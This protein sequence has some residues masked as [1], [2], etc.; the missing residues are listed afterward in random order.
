MK[1]LF[2]ASG[3]IPLLG[4][5]SKT[6]GTDLLIYSIFVAAVAF[7]SH[8]S[9][10]SCAWMPRA[11]AFI[12]AALGTGFLIETLAWVENYANGFIHPSATTRLRFHYH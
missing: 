2:Y 7:T 11:G 3:L 5:F 9:R 6:P 1:K 4:L 8:R 12:L 10:I